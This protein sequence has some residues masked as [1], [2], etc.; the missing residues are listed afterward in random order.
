M[1]R[2]VAQ[3]YRDPGSLQVIDTSVVQFLEVIISTG[4]CLRT[5]S[6]ELFCHLGGT[7]LDPAP[8]T[9]AQSVSLWEVT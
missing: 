4:L 9:R 2:N 5:L 8:L 3:G 1:E 6:V 7:R